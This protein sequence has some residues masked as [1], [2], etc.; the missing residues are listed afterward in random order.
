[1]IRDEVGEVVEPKQGNLAQHASLM[2][3]A[4]SQDIVKGRN[5]VGGDEQQL[6]VANAVH[7]PHLAAGVEVKVGE[8]SM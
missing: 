2:G 7:V 4:G 3:D 6:L 1:M 5:T 8:V